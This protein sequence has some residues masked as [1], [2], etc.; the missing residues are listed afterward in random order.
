MAACAAKQR[1]KINTPDIRTHLIK[2]TPKR[3]FKQHKSSTPPKKPTLSQS[4]LNHIPGFKIFKNHK[5]STSSTDNKASDTL[6]NPD[7]PPTAQDSPDRANDRKFN[8]PITL[9]CDL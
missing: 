5:T 9:N 2:I 6:P 7:M 1:Q 3:K 8:D 4:L